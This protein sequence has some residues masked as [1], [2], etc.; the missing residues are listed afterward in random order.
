MVCLGLA[1]RRHGC[2]RGQRMLSVC[3][4]TAA[5]G[6][7]SG[8]DAS[9]GPYWSRGGR[10]ASPGC[11]G[12]IGRH[13]S[14]KERKHFDVEMPG[15]GSCRGW[16]MERLELKAR[17][18]FRHF[19]ASLGCPVATC[20]LHARPP[21]AM[22]QRCSSAP[23]PHSPG[24]HA[25]WLGQDVDQPTSFRQASQA[26]QESGNDGPSQTPSPDKLLAT[27]ASMIPSRPSSQNYLRALTVIVCII[28]SLSS[29]VDLGS[30]SVFHPSVLVIL[31]GRPR[32]TFICPTSPDSRP[33]SPLRLTTR[34]RLR[35]RTAS[36]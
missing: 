21:M 22:P 4:S 14:I 3:L 33:C 30:L 36:P 12:I 20:G 16:E 24:A 18:P 28:Y 23:D 10:V 7:D 5:D 9:V 1:R 27:N 25:C 34:P 19:G 29:P 13:R 15:L 8:R 26:K 35:P 17:A 32:S 31:G 11:A 6:W 2:C